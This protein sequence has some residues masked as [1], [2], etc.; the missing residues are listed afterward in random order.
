METP[1]FGSSRPPYA[2]NADNKEVRFDMNTIVV[3]Y[4][5]TEPSKRALTRAAELAQ[6]FGA[7][8]VVTSVA[9]VLI[10]GP[11]GAGGIDPVDSLDLHQEQLD[12]AKAFLDELNVAADYQTAAGTLQRPS[13]SWPSTGT[14]I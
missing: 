8:I 12:H 14:P 9:H 5:E 7:K 4:D 2:L 3:G 11:H 13:S 6:A 1:V 10:P